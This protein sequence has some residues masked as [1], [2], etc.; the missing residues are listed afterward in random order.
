MVAWNQSLN[1]FNFKMTKEYTID[2]SGRTLGRVAANRRCFCGQKGSNFYRHLLPGVT[3]T[4]INA[5]KLKIFPAKLTGKIYSL[6]RLPGRFA[7]AWFGG[8]DYQTGIREFCAAI[9]KCYRT[10]NC[11][12]RL[13]KN[14]SLNKFMVTSV[15]ARYVEAVGRR[16]TSIARVRV[17]PAV[18]TEIV[19]NNR[20]LKTYF[21]VRNCKSWPSNRWRNSPLM[22]KRQRHQIF[23]LG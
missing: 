14:S 22:I 21:V 18:K 13:S 8:S 16:K 2:A 5:D 17:T 23:H 11:V 20:N 12:R 4:I 1:L 9:L 15:K 10:I 7:L 3:V 6:Y 19:I